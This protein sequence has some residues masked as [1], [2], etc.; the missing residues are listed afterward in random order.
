MADIR[1]D[2]EEMLEN[3]CEEIRREFSM[4][5]AS[6]S[7][8][9]ELQAIEYEWQERFGQEELAYLNRCLDTYRYYGQMEEFY[10]YKKGILDGTR[11][12]KRLGV[13]V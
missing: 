7:A 2:L 1:S 9:S 11:L 10:F 4:D 5:E 6:T 13:L 8:H 3:R 12:L